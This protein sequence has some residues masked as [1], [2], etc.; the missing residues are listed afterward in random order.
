MVGFPSAISRNG[1]IS[2]FTLGASFLDIEPHWDLFHYF[3]HLMPYPNAEAPN[4][5]GGAKI[6]LREKISQ[7]Y[8][9]V[10]T[11]STNKGWHEE[12]FYTPNHAP[13][14]PCNINARPK[15][16]DC[17]TESIREENMG[18]VWE[19]EAMIKDLKY[20]GLNGMGV[21][22]NFAFCRT[23]PMKDFVHP[24]FEFT[25][26][27][28][29]KREVPEIVDKDGLYRHLK[30]FF[31]N[32]TRMKNHGHMLPLSL[33]NPRPEVRLLAFV[34]KAPIP[35]HPRTLDI[36][37]SQ[38]RELELERPKKAKAE[39]GTNG[40]SPQASSSP[41]DKAVPSGTRWASTP[42][43]GVA[44]GGCRGL[45]E[46]LVRPNHP[47]LFLPPA[48]VWH[49]LPEEESSPQHTTT[50]LDLPLEELVL[51]SMAKLYLG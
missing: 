51:H 43:K 1:A 6:Q 14:I 46:P 36:A 21:V 37:T 45:D 27:I 50:P 12:W 23:Q 33:C 38:L 32:N 25:G 5:V 10:L 30:K 8:I 3:F 48:N 4:V 9:L 2:F 13:T 20:H 29:T 26:D 17:W 34:S 24:A 16:R 11:L 31:A 28:D 35:E 47:S 40:D 15:M 49:L 44:R 7:E 39:A 18:Q 22:T 42:P 41:Q 19:L